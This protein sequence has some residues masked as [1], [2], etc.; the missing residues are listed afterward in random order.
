M[1]SKPANFSQVG[2]LLW[3]VSL[4][5]TQ[6]KWQQVIKTL[7]YQNVSSPRLSGYAPGLTLSLWF[8]MFEDRQLSRMDFDGSAYSLITKTLQKGILP[9]I[10]WEFYLNCKRI[11]TTKHWRAVATFIIKKSCFLNVL[12]FLIGDRIYPY[13]PAC[14]RLP[15][16][17][18][19]RLHSVNKLADT[20]F[21]PPDT[22][23]TTTDF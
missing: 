9:W 3:N 17:S 1:N 11:Y 13:I 5:A 7:F 16:S 15:V 20:Q 2:M 22:Q 8:D 18:S 14:T 10:L 4:L 21:W 12:P 19:S 23:A 6:I